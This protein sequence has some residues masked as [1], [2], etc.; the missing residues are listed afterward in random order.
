MPPS[1]Y[2]QSYRK[3]PIFRQSSQPSSQSNLNKLGWS[4]L[5]KDSSY[6][7]NYTGRP[8]IP[9]NFRELDCFKDKFK[10]FCEL[11]VGK[12]QLS[13]ILRQKPSI[14]KMLLNWGKCRSNSSLKTQ[15]DSSQNPLCLWSRPA[16]CSWRESAMLTEEFS[17]QHQKTRD[18]SGSNR[19]LSCKSNNDLILSCQL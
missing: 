13:F 16:D 1:N 10:Y 18:L 14:L 15:T 11:M 3:Y 8:S 6:R 7:E 4:P 2:Q 5:Q 17:R 12:C 9:I 19:A